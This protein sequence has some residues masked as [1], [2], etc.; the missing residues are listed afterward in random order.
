MKHAPG[1]WIK[2]APNYSNDTI[3]AG[4][5]PFG[6]ALRF[7]GSANIWSSDLPNPK[8]LGLAISPGGL[9]NLNQHLFQN[10]PAYVDVIAQ[11]DTNFD[12]ATLT[13]WY[14]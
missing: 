3:L 13:V 11:D 10:T 14:Y 5:A 4:A 9:T 8:P 2:N 1:P 12:S 6:T 7:I